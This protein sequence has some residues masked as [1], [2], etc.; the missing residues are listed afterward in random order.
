MYSLFHFYAS[1]HYNYSC[2]IFSASQSC[3]LFYL[4]HTLHPIT[5][6]VFTITALIVL[7]ILGSKFLSFIYIPVD[8]CDQYIFI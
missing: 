8:H 5:S 4:L 2:F 6:I 3:L 7:L 1:Y